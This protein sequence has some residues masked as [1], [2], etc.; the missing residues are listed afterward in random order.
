MCVISGQGEEWI[1][2]PCFSLLKHA[3]SN[4]SWRCLIDTPEW[5]EH[6]LILRLNYWVGWWI[7]WHG[8]TRWRERRR[9][10]L[11]S[12]LITAHV[13]DSPL[14]GDWS[15]VLAVSFFLP[16]TLPTPLPS[17]PNPPTLLTLRHPPFLSSNISQ[18][19]AMGMGYSP[20]AQISLSKQPAI[21][22]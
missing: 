13:Q 17:I 3:S 11:I 15:Q 8:F 7:S 19:A 18:W 5:L 10:L 9:D 21:A 4:Y 14:N 6:S 2:K 22:H 1:N 12:K 16:F 20:G